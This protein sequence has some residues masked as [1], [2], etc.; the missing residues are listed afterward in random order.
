VEDGGRL[1]HVAAKLVDRLAILLAVRRFHA[2]GAADS[3]SLRSDSYVRMQHF[4]RRYTYD[5]FRRFWGDVRRDFLQHLFTALHGTWGSY[6]RDT[7]HE[8]NVDV[9]ACLLAPRASR[10][11]FPPFISFLLGGYHFFL[12]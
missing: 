7:L 11:I 10:A 3:R 1:A 9:V 6:L 5:P 2:M 4:F 12:L 8:G